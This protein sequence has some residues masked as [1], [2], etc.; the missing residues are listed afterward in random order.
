LWPLLTLPLGLFCTPTVSNL[1]MNVLSPVFLSAE[2]TE[3]LV[4]WLA[5]PL[6]WSFSPSL[7]LP[8]FLLPLCR[9]QVPNY[10]LSSLPHY[11]FVWGWIVNTTNFH[12]LPVPDQKK[13][14]ASVNSSFR[15]KS[16][17][18]NSAC[19]SS[20]Q[21]RLQYSCIHRIVKTTKPCS[22]NK[23]YCCVTRVEVPMQ[24]GYRKTINLKILEWTSMVHGYLWISICVFPING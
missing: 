13:P 24:C 23:T 18:R 9:Q 3:Q 1:L 2:M 8:L 7:P 6:P 11:L 21:W 5:T 16:G 4:R 17:I 19:A 15:L 12:S 22:C 14:C 10:T 20:V